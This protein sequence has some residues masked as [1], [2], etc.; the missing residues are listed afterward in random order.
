M[1]PLN[2]VAHYDLGL[3]LR[4]RGELARAAQEFRRALELDP[5]YVAACAALDELESDTPT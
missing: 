2:P 3:L 5:R 1:D 4:D